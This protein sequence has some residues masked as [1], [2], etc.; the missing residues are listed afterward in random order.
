MKNLLIENFLENKVLKRKSFFQND[1]DNNFDF[2]SKEIKNKNV[3]V[4]GGADRL[5][6]LYQGN[7]KLY[8]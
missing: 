2:F 3:L 6:K 4:I 1:I 5:I 8:T 7:S